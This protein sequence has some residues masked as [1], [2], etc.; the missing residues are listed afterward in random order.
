MNCILCY[1]LHTVKSCKCKINCRYKDHK[2]KHGSRAG[3]SSGDRVAWHNIRNEC[4]SEIIDKRNPA[5]V[6]SNNVMSQGDNSCSHGNSYPEI[7][8]SYCWYSLTS[9]LLVLVLCTLSIKD[10]KLYQGSCTCLEI[11]RDMCT[12]LLPQILNAY[13]CPHKVRLSE[14]IHA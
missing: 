7:Q 13:H 11:I 8:H 1:Y 4:L 12:T 6:Y 14:L 3:S 2:R 9:I 5:L 10:L